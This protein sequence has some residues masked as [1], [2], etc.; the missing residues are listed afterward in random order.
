MEGDTPDTNDIKKDQSQPD[1]NQ[2]LWPSFNTSLQGIISY[3]D[4]KMKKYESIGGN[5]ELKKIQERLKNNENII[6]KISAEE[7]Q[8]ILFTVNKIVDPLESNYLINKAKEIINLFNELF[9]DVPFIRGYCP[10]VEQH[11]NIDII[12]SKNMFERIERLKEEINDQSKVDPNYINEQITKITEDLKNLPEI[13]NTAI[14][15]ENF[16]TVPMFF[17][18]PQKI[19]VIIDKIR[20][21]IEPNKI[22]KKTFKEMPSEFTLL[23]QAKL[24]VESFKMFL[25]DY[26][27]IKNHCP[28]AKEEEKELNSKKDIGHIV[29]KNSLIVISNKIDPEEEVEK[30]ISSSVI[31]DNV[32]NMVERIE[33]LEEALKN[34]GKIDENDIS[35]KIIKITEDLKKIVGVFNVHINKE[36]FE[37]AV[38]IEI[39][40]LK[41]NSQNG[42]T[43]FK[44]RR[45]N[46]IIRDVILNIYNKL[47]RKKSVPTFGHF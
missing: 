47:I 37:E 6:T 12:Q 31:Q 23:T 27:F 4:S 28:P 46:I 43:R 5:E 32:E 2:E 18:N 17:Y 35:E 1:N 8:K 14:N 39:F 19:K 38:P 11:E 16:E 15:K 10:P 21:K 29:D 40:E 36:S 42:R 41:E 13:L 33:S 30:K 20:N 26:P 22:Q 9:K 25:D 7:L 45:D 24:F 34:P 44:R 3:V